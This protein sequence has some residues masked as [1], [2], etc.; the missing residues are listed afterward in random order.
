MSNNI[1]ERIRVSTIHSLAAECAADYKSTK[2]EL[3]VEGPF[4]FMAGWFTAA[5]RHEPWLDTESNRNQFEK[6]ALRR[7]EGRT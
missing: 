7:I 4:D 1:V 2:D 3:G 5:A 6:L